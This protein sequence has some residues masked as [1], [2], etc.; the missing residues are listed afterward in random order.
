MVCL[1]EYLPQ[2]LQEIIKQVNLKGVP[3]INDCLKYDFRTR[4]YLFLGIFWVLIGLAIGIC[5][6]VQVTELLKS[7]SLTFDNLLLLVSGAIPVILIWSS[8]Y[9]LGL[10]RQSKW[11]KTYVLLTPIYLIIREGDR[12]EF[13]RWFNIREFKL[14]TTLTNFV[15]RSYTMELNYEGKHTTLSFPHLS[16]KSTKFLAENL[17]RYWRKYGSDNSPVEISR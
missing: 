7:F 2:D 9:H 1:F 6:I 16:G 5:Y 15:A 8:C 4:N 13:Y 3:Q 12:F 17:N 14:V 11:G 10:Y